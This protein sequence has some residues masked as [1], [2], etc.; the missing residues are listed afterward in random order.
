LEINPCIPKAWDGF[1]ATR[2]FR[3]ATY[4]ITVQNPEHVSKG[5]K[6]MVVDGG[7]ITG[8]VVPLFGDGQ[9]HRVEVIL[10]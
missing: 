3:G 1:T 6:S 10:G 7:V 8:N 2:S 5:V 4:Q 9:V